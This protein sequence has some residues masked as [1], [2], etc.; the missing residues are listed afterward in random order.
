MTYERTTGTMHTLP[1]GCEVFT[2]DGDK[3]GEVKEIRGTAFK[4][5]VAMQ[6]D[7]WL[8]THTVHASTGDRVVLTFDKEE[9]GRYQVDEP[10]AA[11]A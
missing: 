6:P 1:I 3:L 5:D 11:R 7:Y 4:I 8:P 10:I 9:L 2:R